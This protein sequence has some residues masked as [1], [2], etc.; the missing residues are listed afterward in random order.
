MEVGRGYRTAQPVWLGGDM[1]FEG[2]PPAYVLVTN[3]SVFVWNNFELFFG[4][5]ILDHYDL[6]NN[7]A[8]F[9][10]SKALVIGGHDFGIKI[11]QRPLYFSPDNNF[12]VLMVDNFGG[13]ARWN[14]SVRQEEYAWGNLGI[15]LNNPNQVEV[16]PSFS[17]R[18]HF[19]LLPV[20]Y[21]S[22]P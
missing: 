19:G 10:W 17:G 9:E 16:T 7:R 4:N 20:S 2:R 5:D 8:A 18:A 21:R 13:A 12:E 1:R 6:I 3:D 22:E 14:Y 15:T 11:R